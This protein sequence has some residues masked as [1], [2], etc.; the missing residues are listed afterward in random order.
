MTLRLSLIE[1]HDYLMPAGIEIVITVVIGEPHAIPG[2]SETRLSLL[3]PITRIDG[4]S[5]LM[6]QSMPARKL[7]VESSQVVREAT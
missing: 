5:P 1:I 6:G 2:A 4:I 3:Q 7:F